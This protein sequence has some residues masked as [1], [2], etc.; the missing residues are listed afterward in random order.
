MKS[1][2]FCYR[3][4]KNE[5]F[6]ENEFQFNNLTI[7]PDPLRKQNEFCTNVNDKKPFSE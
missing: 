6:E 5:Y 2:I 7:K 3:I 1:I 4:V